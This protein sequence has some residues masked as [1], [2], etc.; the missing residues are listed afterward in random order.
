M[1]WKPIAVCLAMAAAAARAQTIRMDGGN[2]RVEGWRLPAPPAAGWE[3]LFSVYAGDGDVPPLLGSYSVEG[4]VLVFH[5]KYP[6]S[7]GTHLRAELRVP[8]GTPVTASFDLPRPGIV[9]T[10]RV[11]HVYPTSDILPENELKLYVYF[12]APM[13]QGEAWQRVHLLDGAGK[14]IEL[15]FLEIDQELWD[16]E[17]TRLTI[18]FDPGRIK[19]GLL[20]LAESGKILE[21]GKSYTLSIDRDWQDA[22]GAPLAE[23]YRKQFRVGPARRDPVEPAQWRIVA[24]HA[25]TVE[26]LAIAFPEA[27]DYALLQRLIQVRGPEGPVE[28]GISVGKDETE[29]RF[30]PREP[31]KKAKY[32][33]VVQVALEDLAGNRVGRPFDVDTFN[34]ITRDIPAESVTLE[35]HPK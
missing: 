21:S 24:P 15:A 9:S 6:V 13:R 11:E 16:R 29:W 33:I 3:S 1:N 26:P 32:Q 35:F 23:P 10:T 4:G 30:L 17:H 25:S 5:P 12:T 20:P 19:R 8:G 34:T 28:G 14:P 22:R 7:P 18:L 27:M 2:F 31:W